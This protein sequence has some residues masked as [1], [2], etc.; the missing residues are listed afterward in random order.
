GARKECPLIVGRGDGEQFVASAVPAFMAYTRDVQFVENDELVV[1]RPDGVELL[2]PDGTPVA[3]EVTR[4]DWD[5][6]T[7]E[8]GGYE[9][10]MLKEMHEQADALADT[11]FDRTASGVGVSLDEEGALDESLIG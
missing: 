4:V 5:E 9:T 8:K 2:R 1:L 3:R 6:E 10:F 11:I 7:A